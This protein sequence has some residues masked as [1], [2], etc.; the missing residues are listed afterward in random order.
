[1]NIHGK[2]VILRAM[3]KKDAEMI[4]S[5][6][7]D[8][9][10]ERL[11]GGFCYPMS[12]EQQE[13]YIETHASSEDKTFVIDD[14]ELGAVGIVRL[15]DINWKNRSASVGFKI[16]SG[17]HRGKGVGTDAYMALLRYCFDELGLHRVE[18]SYLCGNKASEKVHEKC[19]FKVEGT[20]RQALFHCG[21]WHDLT[22]VS[23]L[24]EDYRE[25]IAKNN[26]WA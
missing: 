7:N 11:V 26:Y 14:R 20:A 4:V 24:E 5:M 1:M 8:P 19:G 6:F 3:T 2:R 18:A 15:A 12:V 10:T 22:L 23:L 21:K 25:L 9:E 13:R 17:E 16:A